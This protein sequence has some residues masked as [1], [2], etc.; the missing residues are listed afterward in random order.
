[1]RYAIG[2][3]IGGYWCSPAGIQV[4]IRAVTQLE[5]EFSWDC[6]KQPVGVIKKWITLDQTTL[7]H[8]FHDHWIPAGNWVQVTRLKLSGSYLLSRWN[9]AYR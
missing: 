3:T 2:A 5:V 8:K 4:L 9:T 1:M 6:F 7:Y